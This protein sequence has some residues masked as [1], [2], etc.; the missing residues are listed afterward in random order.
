MVE[1]RREGGAELVIL[2][3]SEPGGKKGEIRNRAMSGLGACWAMGGPGE[4]GCRGGGW[5]VR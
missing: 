3:P 2:F 5:R 4:R 1:E